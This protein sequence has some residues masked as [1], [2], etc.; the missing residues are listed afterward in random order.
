[1]PLAGISD[2]AWATKFAFAIG[3]R[4]AMPLATAHHF[5]KGKAA[6]LSHHRHRM[7]AAGPLQS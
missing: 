2:R 4:G 5:G 6:S 7:F 1:M 3:F